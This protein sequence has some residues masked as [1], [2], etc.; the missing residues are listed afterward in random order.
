MGMGVMLITGTANTILMKFQAM[1]AMKKKVISARLAKRHAF[2]GKISKTKTG[3]GKSDLKLTKGGRVVSKKK[4][5]IAKS[6]FGP[7]LAAVKAA[8]TALKIKGFSA[9]KK[10][11]PL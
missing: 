5:A 7:W 11:T 3:L 10:G 2:H 9:I 8:R 4:S 6:S 1:R